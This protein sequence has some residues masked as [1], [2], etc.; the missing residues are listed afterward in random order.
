MAAKK[1][2]SLKLG[3]KLKLVWL[4][5]F[6]PAEFQKEEEVDGLRLQSEP[7]AKSIRVQVVRDA[8][9]QS[10]FL[11]VSAV[12]AG[13]LAAVLGQIMCPQSSEFV[14]VFA[15][16]GTALLLWATVAVRGWEVASF[17][18]VTLGERLNVWVFRFLY[19]VGTAC[20]VAAAFWGIAIP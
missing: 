3:K 13:W 20:L 6:Q 2:T 14:T 9:I 16:I 18:T 7:D 1:P 19:W 10:F 12:V 15:V 5:I 17:T 11:V 4:A 8:Y